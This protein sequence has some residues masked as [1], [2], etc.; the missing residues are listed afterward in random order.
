MGRFS[1]VLCTKLLLQ[2]R[3][4][5]PWSKKV[6]SHPTA[7]KLWDKAQQFK[8]VFWAVKTCHRGRSCETKLLSSG[9]VS[10]FVE[11]G[12]AVK[13][14]LQSLRTSRQQVVGKIIPLYRQSIWLTWEHFITT[15]QSVISS[16]H[17][18]YCSQGRIPL[19]SFQMP[20]LGRNVS[21][22]K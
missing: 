17:V 20:T 5:V 7:S 21:Y 18:L 10:T 8:L 12:D 19:T 14:L 13:V 3:L 6:W 1:C 11:L 4:T 15:M 22:V 9:K 16:P 2:V